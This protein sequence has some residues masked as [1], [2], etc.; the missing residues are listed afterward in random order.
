[1]RKVQVRICGSPRGA[2]PWGHPARHSK[3]RLE[4]ALAAPRAQTR[5]RIPLEHIFAAI[6]AVP[7]IGRAR[8]AVTPAGVATN[9]DRRLG[10]PS[11]RGSFLHKAD[12]VV[13]H[14]F[15]A[16]PSLGHQLNQAL[17]KE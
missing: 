6:W 1:M 16:S 12:L 2:I 7:W 5:G 15:E 17:F 10:A 11:S 13:G 14:E 9:G 3:Q 8:A 4:R